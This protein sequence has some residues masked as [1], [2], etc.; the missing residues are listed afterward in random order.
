MTEAT[1]INPHALARELMAAY[2]EKQTLV[3]PPS[4]RDARFDLAVAYAVE[5]ELVRLRQASGHRRVGRKVGFANKTMWRALKLETLVWASMYDDTVRY[6][7]GNNAS[8]SLAAMVSPKIEPEIVFKMKK[9]ATGSP[10]AAQ[11]LDAV[12]WVA[13]GF[14]IIDCVFADWKFGP[15]DFVAAYG[16]H[17]ALIVGE[18]QRVEPDLIPALVEHLA[19]FKVQLLKDGALVDEGS[20]RNS[21]RSPALCLGELASAIARQSGAEPLTPGE[22]V[23]SGTLTESQPIAPG[24]TWTAIVDGLDVPSLTLS[25][26]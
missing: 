6:A 4:A 2:A 5:A 8:L 24:E 17:A 12:E 19:R 20:G 22:L 25:T 11:V 14:E 21:L 16:L 23:S 15:A 18:P 26:L 10:D 9:A 13:L 7:T 3:V 1:G